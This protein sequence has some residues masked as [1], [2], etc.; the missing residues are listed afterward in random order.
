MTE[1]DQP[2][3][4]PTAAPVA[5]MAVRIPLLQGQSPDALADRFF[6]NTKFVSGTFIGDTL[7]GVFRSLD[8]S[9]VVTDSVLNGIK[10]LNDDS[11]DIIISDMVLSGMVTS[12]FFKYFLS[13]CPQSLK[14]I[15]AG[16]GDTD[17][18]LASLGA[19]MDE[20]VEK[21]FPVTTLLDRIVSNFNE[22]L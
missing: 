19:G 16:R 15:V 12:E 8:C 20:I 10:C 9:V 22:Y 18:L 7:A 6:S 5:A 1:K 4:V 21:P 2:A 13:L 3:A 11:F 14:I 17:P